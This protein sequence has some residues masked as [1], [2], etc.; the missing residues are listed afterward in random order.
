MTLAGQW[1]GVRGGCLAA[2]LVFM[3]QALAVHWTGLPDVHCLPGAIL[4]LYLF[5]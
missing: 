2:R 1:G 5:D 3:A 4:A